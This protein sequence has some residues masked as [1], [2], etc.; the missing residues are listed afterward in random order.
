LQIVRI[1][2]AGIIVDAY[3]SQGHKVKEPPHLIGAKRYKSDSV[4][5]VISKSEGNWL[6]STVTANEHF[7]D[8]IV[9][10][11]KPMDGP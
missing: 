8:A 9:T 7:S 4:L 11:H 6:S 10:T 3:E 5:S 2:T 1:N